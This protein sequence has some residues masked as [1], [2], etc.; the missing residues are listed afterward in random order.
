MDKYKRENR[1][2]EALELRNMRQVELCELTGIKKSSINGWIKQSWQPK[3][4][5]LF[6]MAQVL[7]VSE[8]WLAGYDVPIERS[9]K[10][11][12]D[13][14]YNDTRVKELI[15]SLSKLNSD[16]ITTIETLV[17]QFTKLNK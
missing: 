13:I 9:V 8:M 3:Q 10:Q 12:I 15:I 2:R 5:A 16:Q 6:K 11:N 7:N 1:I 14:I 4:D 17:N